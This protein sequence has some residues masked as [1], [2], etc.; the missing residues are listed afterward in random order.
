MTT[1]TIDLSSILSSSWFNV[2]LIILS[3]PFVLGALALIVKMS[4]KIVSFILGDVFKNMNLDW[5]DVP[6][7]LMSGMGFL[8]VLFAIIITIT[9]RLQ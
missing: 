1:I 9:G 6:I 7:I 5:Y 4:Y 3:I 2:V 8:T